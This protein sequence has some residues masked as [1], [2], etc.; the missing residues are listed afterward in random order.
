MLPSAFVPTSNERNELM[1]KE[2][3]ECDGE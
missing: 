2:V 3:R 1:L